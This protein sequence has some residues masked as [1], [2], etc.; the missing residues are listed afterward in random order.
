[1]RGAI[2]AITGSTG[3]AGGH[4]ARQLATRGWRLRLL[5][6]RTPLPPELAV[7]DPEIVAGDLQ[8]E[9]ALRALVRDADAVVHVAG[10]IK[11]STR[12]DYFSVNCQGSE[13]IGR[14]VRQH[15][16]DS[17]FVVVSSLVA[18]EPSLSPY[19]ASKRAGEEAAVSACGAAPAVVLRPSAIYGPQDRETLRAF[20]AARR[21]LVVVPGSSGRITL[22][23]VADFAEAVAALSS[24]RSLRGVFEITDDQWSGYSWTEIMSGLAAAVGSTPRVLGI[25][26]R[27]L[28]AVAPLLHVAR[29]VRSSGILSPGKLREILHGNWSSDPKA[30]LPSSIWQPTIGLAS[31]LSQTARWYIEHGWLSPVGRLG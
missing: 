12:R 29:L 5:V 9:A 28:H 18:R 14:A 10:L 20:R 25:P 4:V 24:D 11:A 22:L 2:A 13:R 16:P 26:D 15:A 19:A 30:Q 7:L 8:D 6:R 1:M 21:P 23:H 31:G 17:R 27:A 3:F